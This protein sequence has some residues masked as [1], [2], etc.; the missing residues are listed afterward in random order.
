MNN[1]SPFH[2]L[3]AF[4]SLFGALTLYLLSLAPTVQGF[5]SAELTVGAYTLG[6]VHP[7]GYPLYMLLGN[8]FAHFPLGDVGQLVNFMSAIFGS[9]SIW[10]LYELLY[11]QSK[12]WG[13]SVATS[14]LFAT[15]T[16]FWSQ[17]VRAEVYTLQSFIIISSLF[18]WKYSHQHKRRGVYA[19]CFLLLGFGMANHLST[20][21]LWVSIFIIALFETSKWRQMCFGASFF[22]LLVAFTFYLYFPI[23]EK[24]GPAI[25]YIRPYF[26]VN[27]GSLSG[28]A[29]LSS[30]QAFR[31]SFGINFN[32]Q[33]LL[34][35]LGRL[36]N[37]LWTGLLG[38]GLL[39]AAI[40]WG[41]L[42]KEQPQW[43][44]LLTI[45]FSLNLF[46]F[47]SY[48][49]VDKEAM[50]IPLLVIVSF[51]FMSGVQ[52]MLTRIKV[53]FPRLSPPQIQKIV[54]LG[55]LLVIV[56]GVLVDWPNVNMRKNDLAVGFARNILIEVEPNTI[57]V[58]HWIT[59][60]VFDYLRIVEKLRPDVYSFNLDFY[61][62]GIQTD[63]DLPDENTDQIIWF[64]WLEDHM[65][66]TPLCFIEPLPPIP[67]RYQWVKKGPCWTIIS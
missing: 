67:S 23:R 6:F 65:N 9:L 41:R 34:Q 35:E 33:S 30:A 57:I 10:V 15:S 19:I 39:L 3:G 5:D 27:P 46:A 51:W 62:L 64:Q 22:G 28:L 61:L 12:N 32:P 42:E 44:H 25:D 66:R 11:L 52:E 40:G 59:A 63:C 8:L 38:F 24:A 2:F 45:Y 13:L 26:D 14:F 16:Y 17:A 4:I 18:A 47:I 50:F 1:S 29:W 55:I 21:L 20:L 43:N 56:I 60:S 37:F 54:I 48:H 7:T 58:N 36:I 53:Y 49:V 31:C